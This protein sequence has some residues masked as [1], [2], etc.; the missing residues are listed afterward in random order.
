MNGESRTRVNGLV[1]LM[2]TSGPELSVSPVYLCIVLIFQTLGFPMDTRVS[3]ISGLISHP[4]ETILGDGGGAVA[5]YRATVTSYAT[6]GSKADTN[7]RSVVFNVGCKARRDVVLADHGV[8]DSGIDSYIEVVDSVRAEVESNVRRINGQSGSWRNA[9]FS[10]VVHILG[11][12]IAYFRA[13]GDLN[14]DIMKG[15]DNRA[16]PYAF[17]SLRT[18]TSDVTA[19]NG[20]VYLP[21]GVASQLRPTAMAAFVAAVTG[22][23]GHVVT[24]QVGIRLDNT[25]MVPIAEGYSLAVGCYDALNLLGRY[26]N[27][28]GMG[29]LFSFLLVCGV[30]SV[31]TVHGHTD[32]GGGMREI[33]RRV[34][35]TVPYGGLSL[36]VGDFTGLPMPKHAGDICS[37][38]DAIALQSAGLVS[39]A[40][41]MVELDGKVYPTTLVSAHERS[42]IER[43]A[44]ELAREVRHDPNIG[45]D[46]DALSISRM[47]NDVLADFA[48]N[49]SVLLGRMMGVSGGSAAVQR[50]MLTTHHATMHLPIRHFKYEVLNPFFWVE[51]TGSTRVP[52]TDMPCSRSGFGRLCAVNEE[53]SMP[54]FD[55]Y[56]VK[57]TNGFATAINV[58][59]IGARKHGIVHHLMGHARNGLSH[60]QVR[61]LRASHLTNFG[62]GQ[63]DAVGARPVRNSVREKVYASQGFDTYLWGRGHSGLV[64]P[65]ECLYSG[66]SISFLVEHYAGELRNPQPTHFPRLD[67]FTGTVS[68]TTTSLVLFGIGDPGGFN[69]DE[70][71]TR[72]GA[73]RALSEA[74][75]KYATWRDVSSFVPLNA[76][77]EDDLPLE[78]VE[79]GATGVAVTGGITSDVGEGPMLTP[80]GQHGSHTLPRIG[81]GG[82]D[83]QVNRNIPPEGRFPA[84]N[85]PPDLP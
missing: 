16:V 36:G 47:L 25:S 27:A 8:N 31:L 70:D 65:G 52:A 23:G 67:E 59:F 28:N 3:Y 24:D 62:H 13:Y 54:M 46:G 4:S 58:R 26:Y 37:I 29:E 38:V 57:S 21:P 44:V 34:K 84:F 2:G 51:S 48:T 45:S 19:D 10:G 69:T 83:R 12:S 74:R 35:H 32:E 50:I 1:L 9:N 43:V 7:T 75:I 33:L 15:G 77:D 63:R 49:Y 17:T 80:S 71:K 85:A 18:A 53:G 40:D 73:A 81:A 20:K 78:R 42:D 72:R 79:G 14:P 56:T 64:S 41:P 66:E 68:F 55:Q 82:A 30:H 5:R 61:A 60:L 6:I 76:D 22:A 11:A 39:L